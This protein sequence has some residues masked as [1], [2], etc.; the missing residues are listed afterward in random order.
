M[1]RLTRLTETSL[2]VH[3]FTEAHGLIK[4]VAKGARR[5]KSP[6]VGQLDLF[7]GGE[8]SFTHA[9]H[10]ELHS[11]REVAIHQ[12]REGL[13]RDYTSTL[14]A[15]YCCQLL[16][17][18]VEPGH[19]EPGLHDLLKR[20]LDHFDVTAPS[21]RALRHFES[22]LAR[23]LGVFHNQSESEVSL[24]DALGALPAS[25]SDLMQ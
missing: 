11:L 9:R 1:I 25:R 20:G 17:M 21:L 4:T 13:R 5:A 3:W 22:E 2:I 12:W 10:G 24:R 19:P 16:E 14:L 15:G 6:F 7:F 8:M 23:I 18:A